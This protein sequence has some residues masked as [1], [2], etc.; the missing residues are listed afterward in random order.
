[1]GPRVGPLV[2]GRIAERAGGGGYAQMFFQSSMTETWFP[3]GSIGRSPLA[4][5]FSSRPPISRM[6]NSSCGHPA[7]SYTS[8]QHNTRATTT[9]YIHNAARRSHTSTAHP[10]Y[11]HR[12]EVICA[13]RTITRAFD[14]GIGRVMQK[15]VVDLGGLKPHISDLPK[16]CKCNDSVKPSLG[17]TD[18]R[19]SYG[20]SMRLQIGVIAGE[21]EMVKPPVPGELSN[22]VAEAERCEANGKRFSQELVDKLS[23]ISDTTVAPRF[24]GVSHA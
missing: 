3:P 10:D 8:A 5:F 18:T 22:E 13:L 16:V 14:D 20:L 4:R 17:C 15:T 6:A 2:G 11:E 1:M 21:E 19:S 9:D 23:D 24:N 7:A 12:V